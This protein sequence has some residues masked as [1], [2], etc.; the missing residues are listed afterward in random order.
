MISEIQIQNFKSIQDLTLR[1]GRVT[2]LIGENLKD[3]EQRLYTVQRDSEAEKHYGGWTLVL[4]YLREKKFRQA[5][6][7][8]RYLIVQ[9]DTDV[10]EHAGFDVPRQNQNGA[11][12]L[13]DFIRNVAERLRTEIGEPD[14]AAYGDRFIFAIGV[15]QLECWLLP[16]WFSDARGEQTVNCTNRLGGCAQLRD[17]LDRKNYQWIRRERK[18]PSSY[19]IASQGYRK[20]AVLDSQGLR[21]PSLAVFLEELNRRAIMLP[22][23]E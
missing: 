3:D 15:E 23:L 4:Q 16:L 9:V 17:T 2:V 7:L 21:N 6:Q 8:N 1:P 13:G 22:Q 14:W 18:E 5:F 19:H 12:P 11:I 10:A 20:R